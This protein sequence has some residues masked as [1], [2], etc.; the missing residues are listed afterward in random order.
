MFPFNFRR[1]KS[2]SDLGTTTP[3]P[4][5]QPRRNRDPPLQDCQQE[6]RVSL[7][8]RRISHRHLPSEVRMVVDPRNWRLLAQD[9]GCQPGVRR[10]CLAVPSHSKL[11]QCQRCAR[12]GRS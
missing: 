11:I 7:G 6:G 5:G 10:R 2:N 4:G 8:T 9:H 3:I 12:L 1:V